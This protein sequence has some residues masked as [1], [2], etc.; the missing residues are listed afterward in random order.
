MFYDYLGTASQII[1][2]CVTWENTNILCE[3]ICITKRI[4]GH[5]AHRFWYEVW[6]FNAFCNFLNAFDALF[7]GKKAAISVRYIVTQM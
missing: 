1:L 7:Y 4:A 2:L 6:A 3:I 5:L